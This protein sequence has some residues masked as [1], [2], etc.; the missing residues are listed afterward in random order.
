M[1]QIGSIEKRSVRYRLNSLSLPYKLNNQLHNN[2]GYL[3]PIHALFLLYFV[4]L[5]NKPIYHNHYNFLTRES[6]H[7]IPPIT[8][9][10]TIAIATTTYPENFVEF[11]KLMNFLFRYC[12]Y[13]IYLS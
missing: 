6:F 3:Y 13:Y 1:E 7:S 12:L 8:E 9:L 5:D 2:A 11:P 10:I 4:Q